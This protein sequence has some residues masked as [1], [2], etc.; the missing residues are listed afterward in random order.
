MKTINII[1]GI[2]LA[3]ASVISSAEEAYRLNPG[4]ILSISVWNEEALQL[5]VMVLPDG[6]IALLATL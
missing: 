6:K 3:L 2:T 4:D 5:E 1:I